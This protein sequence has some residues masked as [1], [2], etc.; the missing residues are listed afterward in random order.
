LFFKYSIDVSSTLTPNQSQIDNW[1][2]QIAN[3][4]GSIFHGLSNTI[5]EPIVFHTFT[6]TEGSTTWLKSFFIVGV[7]QEQAS[8]I[9]YPYGSDDEWIISFDRGKCDD[10]SIQ[11]DAVDQWRRDLNFNE[12]TTWPNKT[13]HHFLVFRRNIHM[14]YFRTWTME[15][16]PNDSPVPDVSLEDNDVIDPV[17]GK[18]YTWF[19]P[20]DPGCVNQTEMNHHYDKMLEIFST[21]LEEDEVFIQ[22]NQGYAFTIG[23]PGS[24]SH[25]AQAYIGE[26]F[27]AQ[28]PDP[29]ILQDALP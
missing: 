11:E 12:A 5:K 26:V 3:H 15:E 21:Y 14:S 27:D 18:Y 23:D 19:G 1:H 28:A 6:E 22:F 24:T 16:F 2:S 7:G 20:T 25:G 9:A 4:Y 13:P 17:T 8:A 10:N 29:A